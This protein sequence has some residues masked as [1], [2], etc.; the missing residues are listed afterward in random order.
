LIIGV[1]GVVCYM[2][3]VL[4]EKMVIQMYENHKEQLKDIAE[5]K[6]VPV[7]SKIVSNMNRNPD[8]YYDNSN[9][10]EWVELWEAVEFKVWDGVGVE[11]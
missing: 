8:F 3:K 2:T 9:N 10:R 7:V 1:G 6:G 4:Y 11:R 5:L